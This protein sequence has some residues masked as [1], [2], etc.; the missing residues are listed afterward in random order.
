MFSSDMDF[1]SEEGFATDSAAHELLEAALEDSGLTAL[2][3][4]LLV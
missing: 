3:D 1:A 2:A 4:D